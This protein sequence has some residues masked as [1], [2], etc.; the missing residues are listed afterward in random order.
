MYPTTS[1]P[2]NTTERNITARKPVASFFG[3]PIRKQSVLQG[4]R[5]EDPA[6]NIGNIAP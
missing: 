4:L 2:T 6:G 3:R 5:Y 1:S